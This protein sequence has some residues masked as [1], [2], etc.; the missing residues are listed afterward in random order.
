MK[1]GPGSETNTTLVLTRPAETSITHDAKGA[2][3]QNKDA[4]D[5]AE[6]TAAEVITDQEQLKDRKAL[7]Q[8]V[9]HPFSLLEMPNS[10]H[11]YLLIENQS[12]N[13]LKLVTHRSEML[14]S[15]R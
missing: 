3:A 4:P 14:A 7:E 6:R 1:A 12:R 8:Q 5:M 11:L 13:P 9:L 10:S 15:R 2:E